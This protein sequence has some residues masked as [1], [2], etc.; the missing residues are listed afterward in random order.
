MANDQFTP[1]HLGP[2]LKQVD[3]MCAVIGVKDLNDLITQTIP[4]SVRREDGSIGGTLPSGEQG[5]AASL[6]QLKELLSSN[7]IAKNFLGMG[8]HGSLVPGCVL[9]NL[10]ENPGWYTAY[11]P[12]QAEIAQG[13]LESL[14]NFQ[15]MVSELTGM[16][17]ANASLL[18]E[19]TAAAEAMAMISRTVNSKT[20]NEFFVS[21]KVH[22]QT[23]EVMQT[24]A[25]YFGMKLIVGDWRTADIA[26]MD[27]LC[28]AL[29]QYPDTTGTIEDF[30]TLAETL[31]KNKSHLVV[32]ADPLALCMMKPPSEFGADVVVGTMQRFGV[33][34]WFGG[35][36][37]AYMATSLKQVRRMPGRIIGESIDRLGNPAYRL[38][39]QTRE[40]HIRLDKATSNVCTAQVLLAN[41]AAMYGVYHQTTGLKAI[42]ARVHALTKMFVNELAKLGVPVAQ[43]E[44]FFDTV[45][46][47]AGP[48]TAAIVEKLA[49][50]G[51]NVRQLDASTIC[52]SFDESHVEADVHTLASAFKAAGLKGTAT[53]SAIAVN[54]EA[55]AAFARIKPFLEQKNFNSIVSETEMMRYMLLLQKKDLSLDTSMISLGSCTMKLNSVSSLAPVS[56]PEIA[57]MHPFAPAHQ[58]KGYVAMLESLESYLISLTGF[59]GCSLQPTSG[60][61]GEYAGL[62]AIREYQKA[63]GQGHRN[64]C[65]IP[66]SA[67]GTNPASAAMCDMDIKWIDDSG[68]MALSEFRALCEEHKD[69]LSA[70]MIT[71]PSTR[72][73]FED[74]IQ[75]ICQIV[76]DFGGQ[77]YMDGANMNAQLGLTSPGM[78]GAD[79]CH[80]N[81]HKTFSIPHGGGGPGLGPICVRKHLMPHLPSHGVRA[82]T[83]GGTLG[84]VSSAPWGQ[85]GIA[86]IPWMFCTMLGQKGVTDS[87]RYAILNANYM[88]ARLEPY[89]DVMKTNAN[90][91]CAHEFIIDCTEIQKSSGIVEEDI[92]KRLQDYGFHAPTMS[93]PVPHSLMV[94][95]TESED[96]A[97][98]DRFC[99]A[100]IMI[101]EECRKIEKGEWSKEDNPL[102]MA[103]H[104][105]MEVCSSEWTH[106]YTREEAAFP[107]PW[108]GVRGKFWPT[109]ARVDNSLGDRKLKLKHFS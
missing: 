3:A 57:N 10:T 20:R 18:D 30:T 26:S 51:V 90:N 102:K 12:Y 5:E 24:R 31:H 25:D 37:A 107:A 1:R 4:K 42:A 48:G 55:P 15:T 106:G 8:Y 71:Y 77:V 87:A 16:E 82:P 41:M 84:A 21:D 81:L 11:T 54:G 72:A 85:A 44:N 92:A 88:K 96:K 53:V 32:A 50:Q 9:R 58:T 35:P 64:V 23:L 59:D 109:V 46:F 22:P 29:V 65:I 108:T 69:T 7:V 98:L 62:L 45:C 99:D 40:Q 73:F 27:K 38:T 63:K 74:E 34:M 89:F 36:H 14:V 79:V 60:A 49:A 33:P 78:I 101:R 97:E 104:T 6:A 13:R 43:T 67:H 94:E 70:L 76:H 100:M 66:R 39:L 105:Q 103:P 56:W 2:D 17:C 68:G 47:N 52:A 93:W 86:C 95:P 75:E 28:G 83:S 91:R 19:G 80:L 61:S